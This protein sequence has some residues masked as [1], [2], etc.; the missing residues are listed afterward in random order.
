M[1]MGWL[2]I[3]DWSYYWYVL[4]CSRFRRQLTQAVC[5]YTHSQLE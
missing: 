3:C 5:R 2:D 4:C 1:A